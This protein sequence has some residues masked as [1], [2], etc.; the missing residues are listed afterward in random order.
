MTDDTLMDVCV[1]QLALDATAR[2]EIQRA[3][4][5]IAVAGDTTRPSGL[6]KMLVEAIALL[7]SHASAWSHAGAT[8]AAPMSADLAESAF[9]AAAHS[10][11]SRYEEE[12]VRNFD[13]QLTREPGQPLPETQQPGRVVVTFVVAARRAIRDANG[14]D[15]AAIEAVLTDLVALEPEE[16]VALEVVWSPADD[17]DRM[18]LSAMTARYPELFELG[19]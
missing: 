5:E 3:M 10:A 2:P 7:R 17:N 15:R 8:D 6:L 18:S 19:A 1:L 16:L 4:D 14:L 11:R 12:I 9:N 13:G